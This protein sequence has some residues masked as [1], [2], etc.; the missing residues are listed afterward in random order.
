VDERG[1]RLTDQLDE[2][3]RLRREVR[4]LEQE[5]EILTRAVTLFASLWV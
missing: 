5:R 1:D 4:E 2:L 3:R